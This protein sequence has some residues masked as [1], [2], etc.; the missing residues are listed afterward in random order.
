MKNAAK[1]DEEVAKKLKETFVNEYG[2][3]NNESFKHFTEILT[4]IVNKEP[5]DCDTSNGRTSCDKGGFTFDTEILKYLQEEFDKEE[6]EFLS[7]QSDPKKKESED[8][9]EEENPKR[10]RSSTKKEMETKEEKKPKRSSTK[11]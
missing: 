5:I 10:R 2:E 6:K 9:E 3:F 7:M 4:C 8:E 11:T 1:N